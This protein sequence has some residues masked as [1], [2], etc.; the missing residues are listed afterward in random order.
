MDLR[1]QLF[2]QLHEDRA[3]G[4]C[5]AFPQP[6]STSAPPLNHTILPDCSPIDEADH[7]LGVLPTPDAVYANARG[8]MPFTK[9]ATTAISATAAATAGSTADPLNNP[10]PLP[11]PR[12]SQVSSAISP[13]TEELQA[14]DLH[15][16][17]TVTTGLPLRP[18]LP[19]PPIAYS[20]ARN[21][22]FRSRKV[23]GISPASSTNQS[24]NDSTSRGSHATDEA[25]LTPDSNADDNPYEI[26]S[27]GEGCKIDEETSF[28]ES[29]HLG[30]ET[31]TT[32]DRIG[33]PLGIH[34]FILATTPPEDS[35]WPSLLPIISALPEAQE[36]TEEGPLTSAANIS[37]PAHMDSEVGSRPA[38]K[39][40]PNEPATL[41]SFMPIIC[42]F[43]TED[44]FPCTVACS[45]AYQS[46]WTPSIPDS[47]KSNTAKSAF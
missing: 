1:T 25:V 7:V 28:R 4:A 39:P 44:I 26:L 17:A 5:L 27:P 12:P 21:L 8:L 31:E 40:G 36:S 29:A 14:F 22:R 9:R 11:Q 34:H 24:S 18:A 30:K 42:E 15:S 20:V 16:A 13:P 37:T 47:S 2:E 23:L 43:Q 10:F 38:T 6:A 41:D 46:Q 19:S 35:D 3:D 32:L 33:A 45:N